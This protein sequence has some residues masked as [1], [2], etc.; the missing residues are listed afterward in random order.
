M[1][2]ETAQ[3]TNG[4][5]SSSDEGSKSGRYVVSAAAQTGAA[6][7][8]QILL[9]IVTFISNAVILR[10]TTKEMLGVVNVRLLLLYS[11]IVFLSREPLRRA[12]L[13]V[14]AEQ[15]SP[16]YWRQ[17]VNL[18]WMGVASSAAIATFLATIWNYMLTKPDM[19]WYGFGVFAF[20]LSAIIEVMAEPFWIFYQMQLNVS[21]K[22]IAEGASLALGTM[23]VLLGLYAFPSWGL[24]IPALAQVIRKV[25]IVLVFAMYAQ[26]DIQQAA[27]KEIK[28]LRDFFPGPS[29]AGAPWFK[30]YPLGLS[31]LALSFFRHGIVKQL[32]TEGEK[33][34]MTFGNML[35]FAQQGVY[36][37]I[38]N[39]GSLVPRFLF[40][41]IEENYYSFFAVLLSRE[42]HNEKDP[43]AKK[44]N[45]EDEALAGTVLQTLL[46]LAVL[47]G[48]I[49]ACFGQAYSRLLL[50]LYGGEKLAQS[51]AVVLLQV[52]C[53]YV[54]CMA[55]NGISECF[56][57]A[58]SSKSEIDEHNRW[59][60]LFSVV[61]VV[62]CL[63][64][65][66]YFGAVGFILA[67]C[68]NMLARSGKSF[69]DIAQYMHVHPAIAL[70]G[71]PLRGFIPSARVLAAFLLAY[72][73]TTYSETL[74]M[75]TS[76]WTLLGAAIHVA[77]GA[78]SL[79][80]VL[81]T[82]YF[83]ERHFIA[84]VRLL[85]SGEIKKKVD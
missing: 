83:R 6:V 50:T 54:L 25:V 30:H 38:N 73:V 78:V 2:G 35:S 68:I 66:Q 75:P 39:I 84:D 58:S 19:D 81:M 14:P 74:F 60:V 21:L 8:F 44:T 40:H 18:I 27:F 28:S 71:N 31:H 4:D 29:H 11:T 45:T 1:T 9:R 3:P 17:L 77:V 41:P 36:D 56:V 65:T 42:D 15:L 72:I 51:E 53:V 26:R 48:V 63:F 49:L 62:A 13:S 43:S 64:L 33:Y 57:S 79:V 16:P 5:S 46:K 47:I 67:N 55:L 23:L 85:W 22:I 32:L 7:F 34:M 24:V 61:Y 12:C 69:Y 80:L 59:M 37:V 20:A 82:I 76:S 70:H 52:Y 10:L